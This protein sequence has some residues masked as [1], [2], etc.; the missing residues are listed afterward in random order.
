VRGPSDPA[1]P[2]RVLV[3]ELVDLIGEAACAGLC[4]ALLSGTDPA[5]HADELGY[6]GGRPGPHVLDG[7]W[8]PYW[9]RVWG[10]RGLLY[11]W[12]PSAAAAVVAGLGDPHWRVAEMCLK[13]SGK[14]ELAEAGDPA[15]RL[16]LH[17]LTRVRATAVRTLGLVG[18]TEHLDTVVV[19]LDDEDSQV[20]RTAR[21]ALERLTL[22]LDITWSPEMGLPDA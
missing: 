8:S 21:L 15:T 4:A 19:S 10:A 9:A 5:L 13:V 1:A 11:V 20:R 14:R 2:P 16:A 7:S 12:A 17:E 6:L 22:R 18:D 3:A